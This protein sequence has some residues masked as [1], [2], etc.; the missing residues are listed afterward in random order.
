M[1]L[2]PFIYHQRLQIPAAIGITALA[3]TAVI[4]TTIIRRK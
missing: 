3:A 4:I 1:K 2:K